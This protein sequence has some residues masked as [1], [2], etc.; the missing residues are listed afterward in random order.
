MKTLR[1]ETANGVRHVILC[2]A[3]EYNT[4]TPELRDELAQAID[5]ADA[6]GY[7]ALLPEPV[8]R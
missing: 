1:T 7:S 8:F 2:R 5:D 4:I 6:E 3:S